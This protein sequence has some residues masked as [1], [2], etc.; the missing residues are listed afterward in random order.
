MSNSDEFRFQS[1]V[2][3]PTDIEN[4][5]SVITKDFSVYDTRWSE[6]MAAFYFSF[7][8]SMNELE[9]AFEKLRVDLKNRGFIPRLSRESGEHIIYVVRGPKIKE[10]NIWIN[11]LLII[12]TVFTTTWAG[13]LLWFGRTMTLEN[14][15]DIITPLLN[16]DVVLFGF[17]SFALPLM[18]ILGTHETAHY[19]AAK[20]HNIDASLP[21]FIPL[22]PP[23]IL[24]TMGA[25]ISMREPI[26]NKKAL[27]DIGA[28]GPIAGF[29]VSLPVVIIGFILESMQ[30]ATVTELPSSVF[31]FN[32]PLL[33][34]GLRMLFPS[35]ENNIMHPTA[36]AGWVGL[37][38]TALNL[39]PGGQ[40]DGGHIARALFGKNARFLSLMVIISLFV[41]SFITQFMLWIIF[42]F[43]I[44]LLGTTHPPP[45]ND[46]TPLG[47][48]RHAIGA[49]CMVML[50]LCI[51]Y[52]PITQ[53]DIPDYE[54]EFKCDNCDQVVDMNG[55]AFYMIE[56]TNTA[57]EG[58]DVE[59]NYNITTQ[60]SNESDWSTEITLKRAKT[61]KIINNLDKFELQGKES[62][63]IFANITPGPNISYSSKIKHTFNITMSGIITRSNT[64]TIE[65]HV[66]TFDLNAPQSKRTLNPGD[67]S[68]FKIIANNLLD[69]NNTINLDYNLTWLKN[70]DGGEWN[71]MLNPDTLI[72]APKNN[73][74][75]NS[76]IYLMIDTPPSV[77]PGTKVRLELKGISRLNTKAYDIV[78]LLIEIKRT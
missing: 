45:L 8:M 23:F 7:D 18:L 60:N 37:F 9:V 38:V 67:V 54:F 77:S 63:T 53:L 34:A 32:E 15:W 12:A 16:A 42:A 40:L 73:A 66:G 50:L 58:G 46:I 44:L 61:G 20:R 70:G 14:E 76:T 39:L 72:L 17:L 59:F 36:F 43:I 64:Y 30:P 74:S 71:I 78:E 62:F 52:A 47:P 57:V 75:A 69:Q 68:T 28:A 51:H 29:L 13:A 2:L 25:F 48:K 35:P 22:P 3:E 5:K 41:L 1:D 10:R 27:L 11:V 21:Y 65:T 33:F 4:L 6:R 55:T 56:V 26:S 24:G 49:F 31:I 19:M